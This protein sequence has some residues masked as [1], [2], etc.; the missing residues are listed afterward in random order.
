MQTADIVDIE[1][2]NALKR[3]TRGEDPKMVLARFAHG[4]KNKWLHTPSVSLRNAVIDGRE[5]LLT[6]ASEIFGLKSGK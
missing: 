2:Q 6:H 4:V 5:E 3:L 1:L